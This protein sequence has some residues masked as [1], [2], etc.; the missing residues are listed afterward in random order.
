MTTQLEF[1]PVSAAG[2]VNTFGSPAG[3]LHHAVRVE[4]ARLLKQSDGDAARAIR[5]VI[6]RL[7]VMG[8]IQPD[9]TA[10]LQELSDIFFEVAAGKKEPTLAY[11]TV[12]K[13]H[14]E[15]VGSGHASGTA[16]ALASSVSARSPSIRTR[17]ARA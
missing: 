2:P 10:V 13:A 15:L 16:L 12:R 3:D 11:L 1:R 14:A 4:T 17:A 6:D 9:E 8:L 7:A 5:A